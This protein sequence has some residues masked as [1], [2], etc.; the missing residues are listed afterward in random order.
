[1]KERTMASDIIQTPV[2]KINASAAAAGF[3]LENA[4][5]KQK[6]PPWYLQTNL[7]EH[8]IIFLCIDITSLLSA[9]SSYK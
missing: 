5:N 9:N 4:L 1:M 3:Y 6:N 8:F 2:N 7:P